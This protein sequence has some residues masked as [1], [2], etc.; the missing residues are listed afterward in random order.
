LSTPQG[1]GSPAAADSGAG[2]RA[3]SW[4]NG[5]PLSGRKTVLRPIVSADHDFLYQLSLDERIGFRWRTR[6]ETP[7]FDGYIRGLFANAFAQF[8]VA[9][10]DSREAIGHVNAYDPNFRSGHASVGMVLDPSVTGKG[11]AVEA[12]LLFV[13]YLFTLWDFQKIYLE[14]MDFNYAQFGHNLERFFH[15]EARL[16]EHVYFDGR[17]WDVRIHAI[18]R[19]EFQELTSRLLARITRTRPHLLPQLSNQQG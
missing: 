11:W 13:N 18:Y 12:S 4:P 17:F 14:S 6:G 7:S 9:R 15:E 1:S 2:P 3:N 10:L 19:T 16:V 8:V 5:P